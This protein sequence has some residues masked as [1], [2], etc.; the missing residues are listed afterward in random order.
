MIESMSGAR[1]VHDALERL[2][3]EV[4][5]ADAQKVKGLPAV[6]L[7]DRP[8]RRARPGRHVSGPDPGELAAGPTSLR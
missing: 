6:G 2:G 1:F 5:I 7:Q 4:L 3:W 8:D